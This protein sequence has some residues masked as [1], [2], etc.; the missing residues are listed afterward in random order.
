M[1]VIFAEMKHCEGRNPSI[2]RRDDAHGYRGW[3]RQP[4]QFA[5]TKDGEK[6][7]PRRPGLVTTGLGAPGKTV[8]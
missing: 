3:K 1:L 6:P 8:T 4:Q 2:M 5:E 7:E